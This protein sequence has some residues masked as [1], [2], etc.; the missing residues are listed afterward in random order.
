MNSVQASIPAQLAERAL[1]P[2]LH[3]VDRLSSTRHA[4]YAFPSRRPRH[5]NNKIFHP[6]QIGLYPSNS[7]SVACIS[8][9]SASAS[10]ST[11]PASTSLAPS[12]ENERRLL[13]PF[14]LVRWCY[15]TWGDNI[16]VSSD[17]ISLPADNNIDDSGPLGRLKEVCAVAVVRRVLFVSGKPI[18]KHSQFINL[19]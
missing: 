19:I 3:Q 15:Q 17:F 18:W 12:S 4:G 14:L 9:R 16:S 7:P 2:G 6:K 11:S 8:D 13:L 5:E 10:A 1:Y